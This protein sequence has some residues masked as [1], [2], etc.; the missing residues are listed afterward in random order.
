MSKCTNYVFMHLYKHVLLYLC[1][2]MWLWLLYSQAGPYWQE[3]TVRVTSEIRWLPSAARSKIWRVC[4]CT[5][6]YTCTCLLITF[7]LLCFIKVL[8]WH[9]FDLHCDIPLML[10]GEVVIMLFCVSVC[11]D[12]VGACKQLSDAQ[13][14]LSSEEELFAPIKVRILTGTCT[15]ATL[16]ICTCSS[17][18]YCSLGENITLFLDS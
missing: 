13:T 6:S 5:T 10:Y 15:H 9:I 2:L 3:T 4:A 14:V 1:G 8:N 7:H 11:R 16:N 17:V 12:H 18:M